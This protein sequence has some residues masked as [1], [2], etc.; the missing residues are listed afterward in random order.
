MLERLVAL[1]TRRKLVWLQDH[2][3]DLTLSIEMRHPFGG[4]YA[5]RYWPYA[6]I[7]TPVILNDDG[8]CEHPYVTKWVYA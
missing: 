7:S 1:I 6:S 5:L 4:N 8:T 3:G 2:D